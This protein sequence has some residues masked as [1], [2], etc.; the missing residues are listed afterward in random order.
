MFTDVMID[1]E[2]TGIRPDRTAIIQMAAIKFNL[3][4]RT[5]DNNF[6]DKALWIPKGRFWEESTRMWWS[7][8]KANV[9]PEIMQRM[10]EPRAV[11]Q[12][13]VEWAGPRNELRFWSKPTHFDFVFLAGY[14]DDFDLVNPF[15]FR[16]ATD[17]RSY[18]RGLCAPEPFSEIQVPFV[19]D[20]HNALYDT[21]HQIQVLF[22][23]ADAATPKVV[24]GTVCE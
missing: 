3:A 10:E 22:A 6:F 11:L 18:L 5:V 24:E 8:Q 19:G 13:F 23:H 1:L 7:Q 2:T 15:D 20:A 16:E 17:M 12:S 9:L 21:L 4:E 14:L